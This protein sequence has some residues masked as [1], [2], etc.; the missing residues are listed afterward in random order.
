VEAAMNR[1]LLAAVC[2]VVLCAP[3]AQAQPAFTN[4]F[5][6]EEFAARRAKLIDQIGPDAIVAI[7]GTGE[8]PIYVRFRQNNQFFYLTGLQTP[9]AMLLLDGKTKQATLFMALKDERVERMDGPSMY[10]GEEAAKATGIATVLPVD[11][12]GEVFVRLG[13]ERK[14]VYAPLRRESLNS[15]APENTVGHM[16][17]IANDPWDGRVTRE[18]AFVEKIRAQLPHMEIR[19]LDRVL[20]LMRVIKSPRE[21]AVLR[22]SNRLAA[23]AHIEMMR[24][25][26]PGMHEY[27]LEAIGQY[28]FHQADARQGFY[29]QSIAYRTGERKPGRYHSIEDVIKNGDMVTVDFGPDYQYYVADIMRT[30]PANGKFTVAQREAYTAL[31]RFWKDFESS[32]RPGL[33]PRDVIRDASA[34]MEKSLASLTFTNAKVREAAVALVDRMKKNTRNYFGHFVGMDVHDTETLEMGVAP[35]DVL[36][37]GMVFSIEFGLSLNVPEEG[38]WARIE[39][40]YVVTESGVENLTVSLPREPDEIEKLMAQPSAFKPRPTSS[41]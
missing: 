13:R 1:H 29:A 31:V 6:P 12:F 18:L 33:A 30:W 15:A 24:A 23:R 27:E 4:A 16:F 32:I 17:D 14:I 39:D 41:Q 26:K 40:N 25:T 3:A 5:P 11:R 22:E 2:A 20:D 28:I 7:R 21:I 36:K 19:D 35:L 38:A 37:P 8:T 9:N 10:P 34:K